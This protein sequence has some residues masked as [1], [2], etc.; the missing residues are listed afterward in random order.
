[1]PKRD[2]CDFCRYFIRIV[3]DVDSNRTVELKVEN[4]ATVE[5]VMEMMY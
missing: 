3:I 1:M 5:T 4:N 2:Y